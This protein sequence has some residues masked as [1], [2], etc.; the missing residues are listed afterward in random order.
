MLST[1]P[2]LNSSFPNLELNKMLIHV[3]ATGMRKYNKYDTEFGRN[4]VQLSH[5]IPNKICPKVHPFCTRKRITS[6]DLALNV[7]SNR[8][9]IF[10]T[11][12]L[13]PSFVQS[14]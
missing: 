13:P 7:K 4:P 9:A 11:I 5:V 10:T 3:E 12:L 1:S 6:R 14:Q 2:D 8:N